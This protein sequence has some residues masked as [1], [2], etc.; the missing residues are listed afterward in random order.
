MPLNLNR[1]HSPTRGNCGAGYEPEFRSY[2]ADET[3]PRVEE[4][5]LPHIR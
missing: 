2:E 4:V 3:P 5:P 1:R